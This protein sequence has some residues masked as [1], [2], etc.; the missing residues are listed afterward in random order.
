MWCYTEEISD[1]VISNHGVI[2]EGDI[3]GKSGCNSY[4][5]WVSYCPPHF[6]IYSLLR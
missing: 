5:L 1:G 6:R 4:L 3:Y 2:L